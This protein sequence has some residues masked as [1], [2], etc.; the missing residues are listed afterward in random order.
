MVHKFALA[1][2]PL[3][4]AISACAGNLD[5]ARK[6][7]VYWMDRDVTEQKNISSYLRPK[8]GV[9]LEGVQEVRPGVME[10]SLK[11]KR[12]FTSE[13]DKC[14]FIFVVAKDSGTVI[15]WRYNGK[16]ENCLQVR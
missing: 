5:D 2:I 6:R 7:F 3:L 8:S 14:K 13:E 12:W 11:G 9:E 4:F 15:G 16:P 1:C 10:Y